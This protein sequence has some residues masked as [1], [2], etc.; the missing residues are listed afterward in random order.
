[1][2][3]SLER[4]DCNKNISGVSLLQY[5]AL[6]YNNS[7]KN[8]GCINENYSVDSDREAYIYFI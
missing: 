5:L 3:Q 1:M 2:R 8:C 4:V 7:T 6:R